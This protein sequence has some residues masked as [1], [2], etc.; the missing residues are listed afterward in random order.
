MHTDIV[1]EFPAG[2]VALGGNEICAVQAMYAPGQYIAVQGHP[3]FSQ[4]IETEILFNR[5]KSGLF[6]DEQ[7]TEAMARVAKEHDGVAIARV[8]LKFLRD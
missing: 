2:A 3:E 1:P 7:Y 8:F 5:H 6:T 4:E